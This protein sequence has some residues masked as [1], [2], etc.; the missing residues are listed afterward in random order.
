M[1]LQKPREIAVRV[2]HER[3][4]KTH[5]VE[6]RLAA[7]LRRA[8]LDPADRRLV[9]ELVFG[10]SRWRL[11]LDWL[12]DVK[13]DGRT[14]KEGL[15]NLLRLGLYQLFW[16]A[17]VPDHAVVHETVELARQ[18]GYGSQRG[19]VNA[20][21][22]SYARERAATVE[23]L[24]G[25]RRDRPWLGWSH[26]EW[27]WARWVRAYGAE[28]AAQLM[29]WNNEPAPVYARV[30]EL[31]TTVAD[32]TARWSEEGVRARPVAKDWLPVDLVF[33]LESFPS[34]SEL[35]SFV[36]G[37]FYVQ[38]P[39][40]LLA[41]LELDPQPGESVL[42]LCA[43]PGGKTSFIAQR[44]RDSGRVHAQ[45][46][47][48]DRLQRLQDNLARLGVRSAQVSRADDVV[49]PELNAQ[50]DR[51]LVDAPCSN[52]GV[53]RRRIDVRWRLRETEL[54]ALAVQQV[55]LLLK[56][57]DLL[58]PDGTLVYSTCS[59][60]PEENAGVVAG[61]IERRPEFR[62]MRERTLTPWADGVDGAY[63]AVMRKVR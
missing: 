6:D 52:T 29:A 2:L 8:T 43:A 15:R 53:M 48:F 31:K 7:A 36:G 50:F 57:A 37:G 42:D 27:L 12:I 18:M 47:R 4:T 41:V 24:A 3:E 63:V 44:M 59:L 23:K 46:Q 40:T 9:Q 32:L 17:R 38:D 21:L 45:D 25:L 55:D 56:A 62:V 20:V 28:A 19:F 14:Q 5:F 35:G 60:E 58:M 22:R 51:I 61:F 10:V 39:S 11:T 49:F 54:V 1:R 30:N 26:P 16:L 13:T 34:L 33:E